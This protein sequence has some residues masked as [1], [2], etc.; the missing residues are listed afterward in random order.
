M[1]IIGKRKVEVTDSP[2]STRRLAQQVEVITQRMGTSP[3]LLEEATVPCAHVTWQER[4]EQL[5]GP[6]VGG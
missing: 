4:D 1:R 5:V 2:L 3:S 6:R